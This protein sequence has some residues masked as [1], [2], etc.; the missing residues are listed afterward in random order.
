MIIG[1]ITSL[2]NSQA[3]PAPI[4]CDLGS[5]FHHTLVPMFK[6]GVIWALNAL[7]EILPTAGLVQWGGYGKNAFGWL[8]CKRMKLMPIGTCL[9]MVLWQFV[10]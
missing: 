9:S 2:C 6:E 10:K 5:C 7:L 8:R 1:N 4:Q 3:K